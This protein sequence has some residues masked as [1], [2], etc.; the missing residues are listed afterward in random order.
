[1]PSAAGNR[2]R[3][4]RV[5]TTLS[6]LFVA[7]ALAPVAH[8][9]AVQDLILLE[10]DPFLELS[11]SQTY[12]LVYVDTQVRLVGDAEINA[13]SVYFGPSS[14]V[15][16]CFVAGDNNANACTVGR[17][18]TVIATGSVTF[19]NSLTLRPPD[20]NT[21]RSGGSLKINAAKITLGG[22]VNTTGR[23]QGSTGTIQ[24]NA[25]GTIDTQQ[26]TA[27][28]GVVTVAGGGGV[29]VSGQIVVQANS[30]SPALAGK[31][32]HGGQTNVSST[33]G[34]VFVL[35]SI[36]ANGSGGTSPF[37]DGHGGTVTLNG[38]NVRTGFIDVGPGSGTGASST[39]GAAG[40]I[41]LTAAGWAYALGTL[42]ATGSG[43]GAS[44]P[45]AGGTVGITAGGHVAATEIKVFGG[46]GP[47]GG[48][49]GNGGTI[50]ISGASAT[51]G[52]MQAW[53]GNGTVSGVA[54]NGGNI[55]VAAPGV[56]SLGSVTD[57]RGGTA[58]RPAL[59]GIGGSIDI[60]SGDL[61]T[62]FV[63]T[64]GGTYPG[65][66]GASPG[67]SGGP[68]KLSANGNLNATGF[69]T[70]A[71]SSASGT[72][73][74]GH[75]GGNGGAL[76]LRAAT[77]TLT[78]AAQAMATGG[79]G[80]NNGTEGQPGGSG[81]HGGLLDVVSA[82]LGPIAAV[83]ADGGEGGDSGDDEGPGGNG[84]VMRHWGNGNLF[85]DTFVAS[86][87]GGAGNPNGNDGAR[88]TEGA[89]TGLAIDAAGK[90]SFQSASPDA[91]GFH[92]SRAVGGG[93]ATIIATTTSTSGVVAASPVCVASLFSVVAFHNQLG[94]TSTSASSVPFTTQ[95]NGNQK[96][97]D[98]PRPRVK[99]IHKKNF[100]KTP[101][102]VIV[103]QKQ[104][105][106]N[107]W[108]VATAGQLLRQGRGLLRRR[109]PRAAP[110]AARDRL[111]ARARVHREEEQEEEKACKKSKK[112]GKGKK[113]RVAVFS[114]VKGDVAK[115]GHERTERVLPEMNEWSTRSSRFARRRRRA[116]R[117]SQ[118]SSSRPRDEPRRV[119]PG[120]SRSGCSRRHT[121]PFR[122]SQ[123]SRS[124]SLRAARRRRAATR[125][126]GSNRS[127]PSRRRCPTS[128]VSS[129]STQGRALA[130]SA[131]RGSRSLERSSLSSRRRDADEADARSHEG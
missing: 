7:A 119:S 93:P 10:G 40:S 59:A 68:L 80:G 9:G 41:S 121:P 48:G 99:K 49:G 109:D 52:D 61:T 19:S 46:N 12:G 78:I 95:P 11:G 92:I 58:Q 45:S 71:G 5:L 22:S 43:S 30:D 87:R 104:L 105:K 35:A 34:D 90:I 38:R 69:V 47:L 103:R 85:N 114:I 1:M 110:V 98:A 6:A 108:Q 51:L 60:S 17:N 31:A 65:G 126:P 56:V 73:N 75:N 77:G 64:Q 37:S 115:G 24:L 62:G 130:T 106:R 55:T 91:E 16:S 116:T 36:L 86:N 32:A 128:G 63:S 4:A 18:F 70:S 101:P 23:D 107:K 81:G 20:N 15:R 39:A 127:R 117:T 26:L 96:C 33:K 97:R 94:W 28:G 25:G 54:G 112:K 131:S 57:A 2:S 125:L 3:L 100:K 129:G 21:P 29:T 27:N 44:A 50:T 84:G 67:V 8:A 124:T 79:S 113:G 123:R 111:R 14:S 122:L 83:R 66:T 53:G 42:D 72:A 89:P 88:I 82:A 120:P 74:P 76:M 102:K 118:R 13:N